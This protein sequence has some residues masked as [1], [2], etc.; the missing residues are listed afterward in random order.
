VAKGHQLN[1]IFAKLNKFDLN[2]G[3]ETNN[4]KSIWYKVTYDPIKEK[5]I[6]S[7]Q[8][9]LAPALL[10]YLVEGAKSEER[11]DLLNQ[12]IEARKID[13]A[14]WVNFEGKTVPVDWSRIQMPPAI[15]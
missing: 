8:N 11:E 7:N 2:G 3:F 1:S 12:L 6:I 15:S 10:V 13:D 14:Q 4:A 5:M 9:T